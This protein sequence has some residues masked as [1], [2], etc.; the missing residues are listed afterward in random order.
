MNNIQIEVPE[1]YEVNE[2][3]STFT[4]IVFKKIAKVSKWED[5]SEINGWY[6]NN[7]STVVDY[8]SC[9]DATNRNTWA[10]KEQA[11]ASL[12]MA[13]LSQLMKRVNGDWI[14]DWLDGQSPK[15]VIRYTDDCIKSDTY[16]TTNKFLSFESREIRDQFLEDHRELIE[17]A[18]PLL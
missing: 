8:N 18:K 2:E 13:Q 9:P 1:G 4:N 14:P 16:A 12:V 6:I 17:R 10:T 11:E 5:L 7:T 3:L 15:Y